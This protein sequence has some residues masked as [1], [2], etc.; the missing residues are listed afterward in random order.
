MLPKT[1]TRTPSNEEIAFD[2]RIRLEHTDERL[3]RICHLIE[4]TSRTDRNGQSVRELVAI[5]EDRLSW[6]YIAPGSE[7]S[8]L[9]QSLLVSACELLGPGYWAVLQAHGVDAGVLLGK[10]RWHIR[11]S[12]A[13]SAES[14]FSIDV[15]IV[16]GD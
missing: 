16:E 1:S 6:F 11:E 9:A 7:L 14:P 5:D 3:D 12:Y 8:P 4:E 13:D 15:H 2:M 10:C